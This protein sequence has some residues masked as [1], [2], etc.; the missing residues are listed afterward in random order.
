MEKQRHHQKFYRFANSGFR[1]LAAIRHGFQVSAQ[2]SCTE[3]D[4]NVNAAAVKQAYFVSELK[5]VAES[6]FGELISAD[7]LTIVPPH[8]PIAQLARAPR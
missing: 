3:Y 6:R 1:K 5:N 4:G 8:R 2:N 7:H